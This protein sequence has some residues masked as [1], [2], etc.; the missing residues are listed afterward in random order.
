MDVL[1]FLGREIFGFFAIFVW[2]FYALG[3]IV[4][5]IFKPIIF[6]V[7]FIIAF[8]QT[9]FAQISWTPFYSFTLD[10]NTINFI[11]SLPGLTVIINVSLILIMVF[12]TIRLFRHEK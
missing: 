3:K 1:L 5:I 6:L 7:G 2:I 10:T 4:L 12:A 8:T 9:F 11:H